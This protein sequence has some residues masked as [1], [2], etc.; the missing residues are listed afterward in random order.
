MVWV[1]LANGSGQVVKDIKLKDYDNN[2]W[3]V[4]GNKRKGINKYAITLKA[5]DSNIIKESSNVEI[6]KTASKPG[7]SIIGSWHSPQK[8]AAMFNRPI[9]PDANEPRPK[10][11]AFWKM[12]SKPGTHNYKQKI[13]L[14]KDPYY[15]NKFGHLF[16]TTIKSC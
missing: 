9:D 1:P 8:L 15:Q 2:N 6:R 10:R 16:E 5:L 13:K 14:M 12:V 4:I 7:W 11:E 3:I